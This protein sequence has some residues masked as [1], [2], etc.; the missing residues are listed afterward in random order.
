M[1]LLSSRSDVV[2]RNAKLSDAANLV[3]IFQSSWRNTY[4]GLIPHDSLE[5]IV[6]RR[7]IGWWRAQIRSGEMILVTEAGGTLAGYATAGFARSKGHHQG[8]IYE[9]YLAPIYQGLGLGEHLFEGCRY[10][11]DERRLNGLIVWSL[12]ENLN[13]VDF[14][15]RRGGRRVAR[16]T[17]RFGRT[18][19]DK[20]ALGWS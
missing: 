9:L 11:L 16:A 19:L 1:A 12:T 14:Y 5:S 7:D 4:A 18:K 3:G 6:R 8:E 17:E 13:A 20:L 15:E 10:R 2:V